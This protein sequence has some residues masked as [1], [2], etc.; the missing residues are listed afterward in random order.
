MSSE[1][2]TLTLESQSC[3]ID[4]LILYEPIDLEILD[5]LLKSDLLK[6]NFHN[7]ICNIKFEG[8]EFEQLTNY[9]KLIKNG[10]AEVKYNKVQNINF[11]R[12]HP[13]NALG[14]F[15]IRRELRHTLAKNKMVDIDIENCHPVI[16]YQICKAHDIEC[17]YLEEYVLN[18]QKY[19]DDVMNTYNVDRDSAK[20]LFIQLLYFGGFESWAEKL[21]IQ[22]QPT[23]MIIR[24][25]KE[26]QEIGK[27]ICDNNNDI[28]KI[29]K[30]RK[31]E[32]K[33]KDF[34]EIGTTV[35]YYLQEIECRI[36]ETIYLYCVKNKIVKNNVCVLCADGLMIEKENYK[37]ELLNEFE[38]LIKNKFGF[39]LKFTQ[40][41]MNQD[42]LSILDNHL[43]SDDD[44]IK[45]QMNGYNNN[46]DFGKCFKYSIFQNLF[47]SDLEELGSDKYIE[48]FQYTKSF[49]YFNNY[50]CYLYL[51]CKYYKIDADEIETY[52]DFLNAFND[53][54]FTHNKTKYKFCSLYDSSKYKNSF[55]KLDFIPSKNIN[56]DV[57]NLFKGFKYDS[58]NNEYDETIIKPFVDHVKFLCSNDSKKNELSD[59]ILNWM[60]HIIQKP[61]YK[62]EVAIVF[63]SII[64]GAGKNIVFDI[65]EKLLGNYSAKFKDTADLTSRFN[66]QMMAKLFCIGDE[67]NAR[68]QEVANELKDII[69]RKSEIIEFKGKDKFKCMD[70]KNYAFTT[71]NENVFKISNCDRR[72]LF[73]ECPDE[74]KSLN[75]FKPLIDILNDDSK[76]KHLFNYFKSRNLNNFN[77]REIIITD[78]K[79]RL[80]LANAPAYIKFIKDEFVKYDGEYLTTEYLFKCS[81]DY[82]KHNKLSSTYTEDLFCK[83]F[84]KVFNEF[85]KR[86]N[87]RFVYYFN[88]EEALNKAIKNN[89][90]N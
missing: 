85:Q 52:N 75:Y 24:F 3:E 89:Y 63:Y 11:G 90:I 73:I 45:N 86:K 34:N 64:E 76:L 83:Q 67:I 62:T 16:L 10:V 40:K 36:L 37:S 87:N 49:K 56:S 9:K 26:V 44:I 82:A 30:K 27:I 19:L 15:N 21:N 78:Y 35:S 53:L 84:K 46:I 29:I 14:L 57:Y 79:L 68:A 23:K 2:I 20:K 59:Y 38:K 51:S 71:N 22:Q 50:H 41:E 25:K 32:Q 31:E 54:N 88:D 65:F 17:D 74:K 5:K 43:I 58:D 42:Y 66:G 33:K 72:Y 1:K 8:G 61:E 70:Y 39:N 47:N 6:K 60:A 28:R 18:R 81:I 80:I 4:N 12:V 69:T 48:F 77:S 55:S 13:K 7:P